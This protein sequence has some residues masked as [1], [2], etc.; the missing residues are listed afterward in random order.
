MEYNPPNP[1][2]SHQPSPIRSDKK[3]QPRRTGLL[4]YL[5][6]EGAWLVAATVLM[7]VAATHTFF[8][9]TVFYDQTLPISNLTQIPT[10]PEVRAGE[11]Y[12][13]VA[14]FDKRAGCKVTKGGYN[15]KGVTAAGRNFSILEFRTTA[16]GTWP[17]GKAR[18]ATSGVGIPVHVPAGNYII[19][20]RYCWSCEGARGE[21]CVP[22]DRDLVTAMP[23]RV[24]E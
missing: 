15:I 17:V 21:L 8:T 11:I 1:H 13:Y 4:R 5:F 20:W 7:F 16:T 22:S 23:V 6:D 12:R 18:T 19:W 3:A 2:T 10:T 14:K 9:S 24:I